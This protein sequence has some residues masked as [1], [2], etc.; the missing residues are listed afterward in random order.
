VSQINDIELKK[1]ALVIAKLLIR[2]REGKIQWSNDNIAR[3]AVSDFSIGPSGAKLRQPF[4]YLYTAELEDGIEA[5]LSRDDKELGFKLTGPPAI[6]LPSTPLAA[7]LGLRDSREI[8]SISLNHSFGKGERSSP[9]N[10][11]YRDLDELVRLAENPKSVSDDIRLKQV[12]NYLDK[13]A[14]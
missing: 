7:M 5:S 1:T 4:V 9:E 11:I 14:V 3:L 10:L 12:L 8:I 13:L 6:D 2:T